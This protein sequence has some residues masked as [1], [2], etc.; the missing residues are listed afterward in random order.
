[1][2]GFTCMFI[3]NATVELYKFDYQLSLFL[4]IALIVSGHVTLWC[5]IEPNCFWYTFRHRGG[6]IESSCLLK[7]HVCYCI[8]K[9]IINK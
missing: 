1:M 6:N 9:Y 7:S 2:N 3:W 5:I 4:N 8:A